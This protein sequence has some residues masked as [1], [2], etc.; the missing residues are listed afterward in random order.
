MV[1]PKFHSHSPKLSKL[2]RTKTA[3]ALFQLKLSPINPPESPP[4]RPRGPSLAGD[5]L[6]SRFAALPGIKEY[7]ARRLKVWGFPGSH[8][9]KTL[10]LTSLTFIESPFTS[11][12]EFEAWTKLPDEQQ[13]GARAAERASGFAGLSFSR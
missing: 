5:V 12:A 1:P 8:A 10:A 2:S 13:A 4:S 3:A 11:K 6:H 9:Q 7:L